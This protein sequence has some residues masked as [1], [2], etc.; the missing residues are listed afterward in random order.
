M[1]VN[2]YEPFT[3]RAKSVPE[4]AQQAGKDSLPSASTP[5]P[6]PASSLPA[7]PVTPKN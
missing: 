7:I 3:P 4:K 6:V 5:M 1:T 2:P